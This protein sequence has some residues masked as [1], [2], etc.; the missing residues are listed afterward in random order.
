[1]YF[2]SSKFAR[3]KTGDIADDI[4]LMLDRGGLVVLGNRRT[5]VRSVPHGYTQIGQ[6]RVLAGAED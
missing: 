2:V 6:P 1:M 4:E 5:N 3:G